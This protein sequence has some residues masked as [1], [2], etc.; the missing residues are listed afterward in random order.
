MAGRYERYWEMTEGG[1]YDAGQHKI[2]KCKDC[3]AESEAGDDWNGEP[4]PN[5]CA[6][7]CG[8][9]ATDWSPGNVSNPY[10]KNF[11]RIFPD[12]PGAGV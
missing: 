11:D 4:D 10:R 9:R 8:S 3:G 5:R 2:F 12:A 1:P 6:A 7:H